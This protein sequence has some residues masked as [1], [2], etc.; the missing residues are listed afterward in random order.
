MAKDLQLSWSPSSAA[1]L[2]ECTA[3]LDCAAINQA[4]QQV[5]L[6]QTTDL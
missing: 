6:A 4:H 1:P 3:A 2:L 5:L